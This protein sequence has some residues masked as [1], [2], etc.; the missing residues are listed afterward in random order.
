MTNFLG[1]AF[2]EKLRKHNRSEKLLNNFLKD[3]HESQSKAIATLLSNTTLR[4]LF[5]KY[6]TTVPSTAATGRLFS[7]GKNVLKLKRSELS[8]NSITMI[9]FLK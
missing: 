4:E 3:E 8:D 5:V 6:N 7:L 2:A 9:V 1:E